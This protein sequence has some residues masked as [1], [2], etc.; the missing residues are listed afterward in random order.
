MICQLRVA[1]SP[2]SPWQAI[3]GK[4]VTFHTD[5]SSA[6]NSSY[7]ARRQ[8]VRQ[9]RLHAGMMKRPYRAEIG[10]AE[11]IVPAHYSRQGDMGR[12][13]HAALARR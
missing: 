4:Q 2:Q 12:V 1:A 11:S 8:R 13:L 7:P 5:L 6:D 3:L 10:S 9:D